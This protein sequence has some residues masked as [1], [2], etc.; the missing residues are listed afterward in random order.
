MT[1][2]RT[3]LELQ[4]VREM[5]RAKKVLE[6]AVEKREAEGLWMAIEEAFKYVELQSYIEVEVRAKPNPNPKSKPVT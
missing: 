1:A 5:N 6:V 2:K 3:A 4:R